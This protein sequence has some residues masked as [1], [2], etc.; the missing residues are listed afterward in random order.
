MYCIEYSIFGTLFILKNTPVNGRMWSTIS[1]KRP[2][3]LSRLGIKT[4][5]SNEAPTD[6]F[7]SSV[8][9]P[10]SNTR[11]WLLEGHMKWNKKNLFCNCPC[12]FNG[13]LFR[14]LMIFYLNAFKAITYALKVIDINRIALN[15]QLGLGNELWRRML[16]WQFAISRKCKKIKTEYCKM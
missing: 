3:I 2:S 16:Y 13:P 8:L 14:N 9:I 7:F 6:S 11:D 4:R 10:S 5:E 1:K 12:A 15:F